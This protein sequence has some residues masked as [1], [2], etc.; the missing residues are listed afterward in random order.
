MAS[1]I[2]SIGN[3]LVLCL[4]CLSICQPFSS[5]KPDVLSE[6]SSLSVGEPED[7]L[8]SPDG[9]F[10][11]GFFPVG[12][13]AYC[14]AVWFSEPSY[15]NN[16]KAVVWMANRD[17][18]VNGRYSKLT[19]LKTGNLIL[20]DAGRITVWSTGT[21]SLSLTRLQL[22]DFG[23]LVLINS[24]NVVLWQSFD[25]PTDTLLTDQPLTR[26]TKLVSSRSQINS[27][28]GFY[29][30]FFDN[31]NILRLLYE[32]IEISS[33]YWPDPLLVSW[34]AGRSTYNNSKI[35]I[36]DSLG[37]FSSSD[38]FTFMSADYGTKM[39][40]RLKIDYDGNVRLYSRKNRGE[41]WVVSW[42]A[43]SDPC[44]IHGICGANS[45][46]NYVP[47]MGRKCS[48]I[49]GYKLRNQT[50]WSSG[51]VPEF[52]ISCTKHESTFLQISSVGLYGYEYG[53]F[54]NYT[55]AECK[56]LCLQ[57]CNCKGFQFSYVPSSGNFKCYPKT[58]LLNG[59]REQSLS[60]D[61]Y[62]RLPQSFLLSKPNSLVEFSLN[63]SVQETKQLDRT[64]TQSTVKQSV[65][66]ILW[67]ACG[68]G[69]FEVICILLVWCLLIRTQRNSG[70]EMGGY[71]LAATGFRRFSFAELHKATKR[72]SEEIGRGAGGIVYKGVL[73]DARVAAIK[74][75]KEANQGEAEFLAEVNTIGRLNH[76]HLIEMWGYCTEGKHR[77]L[78]YEYLENGSLK[79]NLSS[80]ML[81]WEKR[82]GIALG[83]AKGLAY[84]H[85]ECLEWV[86]HCDV[87]PQNILLDSN[88]QP[89]IADFGMSKL[90]KRGEINNSSVS[91]IRGTRGYMAPEWVSNRPITSKVDVYSYGIVVLEM[92]TG[93]N[94]TTKFRELNAT[95][96]TEHGKLVTWVRDKVNEAPEMETRL[97]KVVDASARG[98]YNVEK[99][100]ILLE[101]ALKCVEEDKDER[102]DMSQV[103]K[104]LL[105]HENDH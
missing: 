104:T 30:L 94:P 67:F 89:K 49:P 55:L 53:I 59:Y 25:S 32:S 57:L 56:N 77:L 14:F 73:C 85:E 18:P 103:V 71:L 7:V 75:L 37:N 2:T 44:M 10:S 9:T 76:M 13:N 86:L 43:F 69:G 5:S 66:F 78:V 90:L 92:L 80:N 28:S 31:D 1:V 63:C 61:L 93:K 105:P 20:T 16:N 47:S 58:L 15:K 102:P 35:A 60:G 39:Q 74:R 101:V 82:F 3:F 36:L 48:C 24:E 54:S 4:L 81:D 46:C 72:F 12:E 34:D 11:A 42:Q 51:C 100:K 70:A 87:K 38:D 21:D 68:L 33:V 99:M 19:L 79:E 62:L 64:Y 88:H 91:K 84:L 8:S 26:Y 83:T 40:R 6:G 29:K 65:K 22:N 97:E 27:S 52:D 45:L 95:G 50:D 41:R 23:N 96:E 98:E 17:Q